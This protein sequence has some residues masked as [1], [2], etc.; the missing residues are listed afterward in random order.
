MSRTPEVDEA[1]TNTKAGMYC[2]DDA[3]TLAAEVERLDAQ[4]NKR[5][6]AYMNEPQCCSDR[7]C[8]CMGVTRFEQIVGEELGQRMATMREQNERLRALAFELASSL[9]ACAGYI[10]SVRTDRQI[11]QDENVYALQTLEW[12]EGAVEVAQYANAA[13]EAYDKALNNGESST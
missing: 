11:T 10:A 6:D 13:L 7:E 1:I 12:A 9:G 5:I 8:G 4:L 2:T 3:D